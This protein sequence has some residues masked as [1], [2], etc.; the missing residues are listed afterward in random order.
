MKSAIGID[1]GKSGAFALVVNGEL[2]W[3]ANLPL[4]DDRL[5]IKQVNLAIVAASPDI[6]VIEDVHSMPG[7]G[8]S[9]VFTFGRAYGHL[10]AASILANAR[11]E[12]FVPTK[13]MKPYGLTRT[14][15]SKPEKKSLA[16]RLASERWP[17]VASN[18]VK[19]GDHNKAE[20]AL[21]AL[22]AYDNLLRER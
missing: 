14:G 21:F 2:E 6:V 15:L 17:A 19:V 12:R 20:A 3:V 4:L 7:Q 18:F 13:W 22:W 1:P 16:R 8:V 11:V 9:S 10:E 5:D